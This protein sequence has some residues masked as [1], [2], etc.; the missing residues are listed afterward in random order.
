M[1]TV[2][3][4]FSRSGPFPA[5]SHVVAGV[6]GLLL[7][8]LGGAGSV[9]A[10]QSVP[11]RIGQHDNFSRLVFAMPTAVT[12]QVERQGNDV[13]LRLP[14][15]FAP[16]LSAVNAGQLN[17]VSGAALLNP[18]GDQIRV[19]ITPSEPGAG[20]RAFRTGAA[21]VVDVLSPALV[22]GADS[23]GSADGG[24][25]TSQSA[26][27]QGSGQAGSSGEG[28]GG[29]PEP[30]TPLE[31]D[32]GPRQASEGD[33][34]NVAPRDP[35]I[36]GE[37]GQRRDS[38]DAA[39]PPGVP[40][41]DGRQGGEKVDVSPRAAA[42]SG[43]D[44]L[45]FTFR[46]RLQRPD[47]AP[48]VSLE[49]AEVD[50]GIALSFLFGDATAAAAAVF[51]RGSFV[52]IVFDRPYGLDAE[53]LDKTRRMVGRRIKRFNLIDH[54][55]ALVLRLQVRGNQS[56][57]IDR[58]G[59]DWIVR[60]L[61]GL[62]EPR[63]PLTPTR[64][65]REDGSQE[66]FVAATNIGRRI[67]VEDPAVGDTLVVVTLGDKST[68][69]TDR[70]GFSA[71]R[72]LET[73]Q[74]MAIV[75]Q[76]D[77][78]SVSRYREGVSITAGDHKLFA[79]GA[80]LAV[81]SV[82]EG[83]GGAQLVNFHQWARGDASDFRTRKSRLL[84]AL[85]VAP[86]SQRNARRWPLARFYL[87]H[88][89]GA[90][91]IGVLQQMLARES[92]LSDRP[93]FRILRG[94]ARF[95]LGRYEQAAKDLSHR[96]LEAEQHA[97][98]WRMLVAERQGRFADAL[99]HYRRGRDLIGSYTEDER[100]E[101]QFAIVRS[102][103]QEGRLELAE[104]ELGLL[105][106]MAL[107]TQEVSETVY[108]Q[109][110]LAE[111]RGLT[112]QALKTYEGLIG[113]RNREVA[114]KARL[115][116]VELAR[117]VKDLPR[118]DLIA[119]LERLRYTW[120]G[121]RFELDVMQRLGVQ[122]L[123]SGQY[124]KGLA[125]LREAVTAFPD[126]SR[127]R[128]LAQYMSDSFRQLYLGGAAAEMPAIEAISLFY[129]FRELTPLGSDGDLMIRRLADRLVSV[130]LLDRAAELLDY[131][132]RVRTEGAPRAQIA[133]KLAKIHILN[134][135]P[136]QALEVLRATR[137]PRL[138]DDI[139]ANRRYVEARA[140]TE[141][142]KFQEAEVLL[143]GDGS[144][145]AMKIRADIYWGAKEWRKLVSTSRRLLDGAWRSGEP[146]EGLE[147]LH[148]IRMAIAMTFMNDREGLQQLRQRYGGLMRDGDFTNA[149]EILTNDQDLTGRELS[150][151]AS[152]IASVDKL[153]SFMRDYRSD[154]SG[155]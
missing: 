78:V 20:M 74:G 63:F 70:Y 28:D 58:D 37:E 119:E 101:M 140:L 33:L 54:P 14:S 19:R 127:E 62:A 25:D 102:A 72:I 115:A 34:D 91:A 147:R 43:A 155:R 145:E 130:D 31:Q 99:T 48:V 124:E 29:A 49:A 56:V 41:P 148:L 146:L 97:E 80:A 6:F 26:P 125:M 52:W 15:G 47:D 137:E 120:R 13:I 154:F 112:D 65:V 138:P 55:D 144:P 17:E 106:G 64:R 3:M 77:F 76:A 96:T 35:A 45:D 51:E 32:E 104:E 136:D 11:V 90:E 126:A 81:G 129:Q 89:R 152:E 57:A 10:Q 27:G 105:G 4:V 1:V 7:L 30:I 44:E 23:G 42:K 107:D 21:I 95:M 132:I 114:A 8:V 18:D 118:P 12:Y 38:G 122:Y 143:E 121:G 86:D 93:E 135:K 141:L 116:R 94:I 67:D 142:N 150:D 71:V 98:L 100:V 75:P 113:N 151:I 79:E 61:D 46:G 110:R 88:G 68:G 108:L 92:A 24:D 128:G 123:E 73:A 103:L 53:A 16:D 82:G 109:G 111:K 149:F 84:Y 131:Q 66:V 69:F 2:S 59:K 133:A 5:L 139:Q 134:R 40:R 9:S 22:S 39:S 50:D 85:S 87:A 36:E 153:Q 60:F 83:G 117:K